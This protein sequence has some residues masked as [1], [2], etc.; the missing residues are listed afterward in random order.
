[1]RRSRGFTLLEVI[2]TLLVLVI[3]TALAMPAVGRGTEG[4]RARS[5]A[6]RFS[7]LLRHTR[8]QAITA[9]KPH[10]VVIDPETRRITVKAGRDDPRIA[11][12]L[13]ERV[14]ID[15]NPPPA[16][17]V[18]FE[19]YGGSSGGDFMLTSS[20]SSVFRYHITVDAITGRVKTER[21]Q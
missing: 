9:R 15:A 13:P 19:P 5:D 18:R 1:M 4:L 17:T 8:E 14:K 3:A 12:T 11:L 10:E 2:V 7:A 6:T 21:A 20:A 16:L